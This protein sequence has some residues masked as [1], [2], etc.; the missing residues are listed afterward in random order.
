MFT[1]ARGAGALGSGPVSP[2]P[3]AARVEQVAAAL[4]FCG[5]A[6]P[7]GAQLV[8]ETNFVALLIYVE[9]IYMET[10]MLHF[11]DLI[12]P[13]LHQQNHVPGNHTVFILD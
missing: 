11:C 13:A 7:R 9:S 12:H 8:L 10:V 1:G 2:F 4:G 5:H 3:Q 6:L